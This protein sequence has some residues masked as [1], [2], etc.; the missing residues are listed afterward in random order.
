[1]R[2]PGDAA[3]ILGGILPLLYLTWLGIR[4]PI[5]VTTLDEPDA[6]LFTEITETEGVK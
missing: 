2:F 1:L 4:R 5:S 3:F 6:I